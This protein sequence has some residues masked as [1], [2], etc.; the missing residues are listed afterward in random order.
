VLIRDGGKRK[1]AIDT[2]GLRVCRECEDRNAPVVQIQAAKTERKKPERKKKGGAFRFDGQT[3]EYIT[4]AK[5]MDDCK[6]LASML[7]PDT[8]RI[9]GVARSGLCAASMVAMLL[10]RP[11]SIVRQ[12]L[13][14]VVD[15][16]NG[17]RLHDH[18][19]QRGTV[20]VIDDTVMTGNSFKAVLPIV[21]AAYP[22]ALSAAVYV[23]PAAKLKPDLWVRDLPWPHALEWNI[24][25]SVLTPSMAFD[26]DGVLCH[27]CPP[28]DDY[29]GEPYLRFLDEAKP[30]YHVRKVEI[31]LIVTARLE[32]YRPQTL[33]WLARHGMTVKRLVMGPWAS[34]K[35][36]A[37]ADVAA[38]K[39]EHYRAFLQRKHKIKPPMFVESDARQAKRIAEL[40]GGLV[41]SIQD[42]R[43]YP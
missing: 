32:K 5:L 43:F 13:G 6:R 12:S 2:S 41:L 1:K 34:H 26:F 8:S 30:L 21:R 10:H 19:E 14:D 7:P 31:P 24:Y 37:K 16:G 23:N 38:Y 35:E 28:L 39:A 29:D 22:D 4:T 15:G 11:L 18:A 42:E 25:Q 36:R 17:W 3:P 9:I 40:S 27:D 33:A 20:V